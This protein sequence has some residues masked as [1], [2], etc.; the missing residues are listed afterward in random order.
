MMGAQHAACGAAAWVAVASNYELPIT[1]VT[2]PLVEAYPRLAWLPEALPLGFGL[3]E[4]G[5]AAVFMGAIICAGAALLP[6][7]DHHNAS[8]AHSL[9][10]MT[11]I[12]A[13]FFQ[14]ASGGHRNGTHSIVGVV[15][16]GVV[17]WLA[18]FLVIT[19]CGR[20]GDLNIGAG[21]MAVILSAFA[22][23][24]LHFMPDSARRAPWAAGILVGVITA[25]VT[26]SG[27]SWLITCIVLG[28][29]VHIVGDMLTKEGC[30][31]FWPLTLK[32]PKALSGAPLVAEVWGRNG[33]IA[34]P[35]LGSANSIRCWAVT[36][37]ISAV[38]IAGMCIAGLHWAQGTWV[39]LLS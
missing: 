14:K 29:V 15:F 21:L 34:I 31:I 4:V 13:R 36:I 27:Q 2:E 3:L 16:F 19:G 12:L 30:N 25:V 10:P 17:A 38:A 32:R 9:P 11:K 24:V 23:K 22:F 5:P 37:P 1:A 26:P 35:L 18:S 28:V 7:I 6:D 8:I 20:F 33:R 39:A